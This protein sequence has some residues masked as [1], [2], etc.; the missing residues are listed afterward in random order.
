M[1]SANAVLD[2]LSGGVTA[3]TA[4]ASKAAVLDS[5]KDLS[6]VRNLGVTN[7]DAGASGTAGSVDLF[8][9]TAAKGK[10]SFTSSDNTTNTTTSVVV[11]AQAAA[12]TLTIPDPGATTASFLLTTGSVAAP[13]SV[14]GAE[15]NTLA[16]VTGGTTSASK[17]LVTDASFA[18]AGL[19][20]PTAAKTADYTVA[21]TDSG[22]HFTNT[23]AGGSINFTLPSVAT[24]TGVEVWIHSLVD[25]AIVVTAPSGTLVGPNNAGRT[26]YTAG[27]SG[28]RI[29]WHAQLYCDGA[30]WH[31]S[32]HLNGL[33]LGAFA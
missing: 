5:N 14:T 1:P 13:P 17:A 31:I 29:G 16:G 3:G 4:K 28:Q 30:K 33:T 9:T 18:L 15:L 19:R 7:L 11:A 10:T 20:K 2:I 32:T 22:K 21:I 25:Q 26:S 6:G 12:R 27:A 23:G 8:P 24:S